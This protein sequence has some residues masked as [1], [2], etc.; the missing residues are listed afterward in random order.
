MFE[1]MFFSSNLSKI[2]H[3]GWLPILL[4]LVIFTLLTTWKK[5]SELIAEHRRKINVTMRKF[6][7]DPH[8]E[9]PRVP[10]TAVYLASNP[11]LVPSRLFYNIKHYKVMHEQ[12]VFLHVDNEEVPYVEEE[13]RLMVTG[14]APG[15]YSVAVRFG[16]R[17]D[18]DLSKALRGT[19]NYQLELPAD[20]TTFFVART[21]IVD[22]EGVLPYWRCALFG[23]MMRQS[24]S[25]ATYFNLPS[26]QVVEIGT[27]V[28]L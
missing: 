10:G 9:I 24:E 1:I 27:Q 6:V 20:S 26:D 5:G 18:P 22:C 16:F 2:G 14:L 25:A 19:V 15:I 12:I 4:G 28:T 23:W 13:D 3:G 11:N 21:A 7:A 17:E 8:S